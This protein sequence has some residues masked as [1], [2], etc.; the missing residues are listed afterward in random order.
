[1]I[2]LTKDATAWLQEPYVGEQDAIPVTYSMY[3][4]YSMSPWLQKWISL[5]ANEGRLCLVAWW[6]II[7]KSEYPAIVD[8]LSEFQKEYLF[9][10][11]EVFANG[12]RIPRILSVLSV[13]PDDS[14]GKMVFDIYGNE[15]LIAWGRFHTFLFA[16][17]MDQIS[18]SYRQYLL[19]S[20]TL[21]VQDTMLPISRALHAICL[22]RPDIRELFD[23][24]TVAGRRG[25]VAWQFISAR[26]KIEAL[27]LTPQQ[28]DW[29][30]EASP[31]VE[32][33][34]VLPIS[35]ALHALWIVR[36]DM[37]ELFD[38]SLVA[39][40]RGFVAWQLISAR[41]NIETLELT[42]QQLE[43]AR[44]A[45]PEVEQDAM[46]PVSRALYAVWL[47]RPDLQDLFDLS[48]VAGRRG[49]VAWQVIISAQED[50]EALK[51]TPQ[52]LEWL[53]EASPEVEQ[54]TVLPISRALHALWLVR[55]DLQHHFDLSIADGRHAF[56]NWWNSCG[57]FEIKGLALLL[58]NGL[59]QSVISS[60]EGNEPEKG[61]EN[62]TQTG[63]PYLG[64]SGMN[65][66]GFARGE[67]GIGE[68]VRMAAK[69]CLAN[70]YPFSIFETQISLQSRSKDDSFASF[71]QTEPRYAVNVFFMPATDTM[72]TVMHYGNGLV[73]NR[74]NIGAWQWELPR[75]PEKAGFFY[76]CVDE[77][78]A[79]SRYTMNAFKATAP[80]PVFCIPHAVSI[81]ELPSYPREY[82]GLPQDTYLF[83][84]V[85]DGLSRVERK[86]PYAVVQAFLAAFPRTQYPD[87]RLVI[88]TMNLSEQHPIIQQIHAMTGRDDRIIIIN[89]AL[90]RLEVLELIHCCDAFVSLHRAEGFGRGIAEAMLLGRPVIV[91]NYSGN[92]DFTTHETAYLVEGKMIDIHPGEYVFGEGQQWFDADAEQAAFWMRHCL[93][94]REDVMKKTAAAKKLIETEYSPLAVGKHYE[95][96]LNEIGISL[97]HE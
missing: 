84:F 20:S 15:P 13:C 2:E 80:V 70:D 77:I 18:I 94:E 72:R 83:L 32:Q 30:R 85:F 74:Y 57:Q 91:S 89:K 62:S 40:R 27:E 76:K 19:E 39:G 36:P 29:L 24:E 8:S 95:K 56:L 7:G 58:N 10:T 12:L 26:E 54:D 11:T 92:V 75:W 37:Q 5:D 60:Q 68:D 51:L 21:V 35:R 25:L 17:A 71:I 50:I 33:D 90:M 41:E 86:N 87:V 67:L 46:L 22:G 28:K 4:L 59:D 3:A 44:E 49:L 97:H 42:P 69:S 88:K 38:L 78:W 93:E 6:F 79:S 61:A 31:E 47:G 1:M 23:L 82:F 48:T 45:S 66:I 64:D 9:E 53:R 43:W 34:T 52:Q 73:Q 63:L 96:R 14:T 55:A 16:H 65:I 81:P